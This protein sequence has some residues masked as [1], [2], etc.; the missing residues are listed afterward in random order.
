MSTGWDKEILDWYVSLCQNGHY[1]G[2]IL[3]LDYDMTFTFPNQNVVTKKVK[4]VYNEIASDRFIG[5]Y[6]YL[7]DNWQNYDVIMFADSDIEF[8]GPIA[9]LF[10]MA[11]EKLC[12]VK[13]ITMWRHLYRFMDKEYWSALEKE[14][15]INAAVIVGPAKTIFEVTKF[16]AENLHFDGSFGAD[17]ILLSALVY[18]YKTFSTQ[19]IDDKWNFDIR[20]GIG[21]RQDIIILH[22]IGTRL[23]KT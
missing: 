12:Y 7:K 14:K 3:L 9:P 4:K 18:Y 5:F 16:I 2:D 8:F 17:Q 20:N 22:R 6:E 21:S 13:E 11:K 10:E 15:V 1:N 19:E 23:H